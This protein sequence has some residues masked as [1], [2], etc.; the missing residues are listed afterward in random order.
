MSKQCSIF[1]INLISTCLTHAVRPIGSLPVIQF[2]T[3]PFDHF[4]EFAKWKQGALI[5]N[6]WIYVWND[7]T[8]FLCGHC[9]K[10]GRWK[11]LPYHNCMIVKELTLKKKKNK[12]KGMLCSAMSLLF[13]TVDS[14]SCDIKICHLY[15]KY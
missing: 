7:R 8:V 11:G 5:A 1:K 10:I 14:L 13:S 4:H 12:K 9:S 2:P 6:V 3:Y 15:H